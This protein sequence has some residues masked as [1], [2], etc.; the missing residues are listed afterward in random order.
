MHPL[1]AVAFN[2][3][4]LTSI[5]VYGIELY[6]IAIVGS[7]EYPKE[8][9][10]FFWSGGTDIEKA[11]VIYS[12]GTELKATALVVIVHADKEHSTIIVCSYVI[13]SELNMCRL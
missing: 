1:E 8:G 9:T 3:Y 6:M 4:F 10:V 11:V 5:N 7:G 13:Y 12:V 2:M